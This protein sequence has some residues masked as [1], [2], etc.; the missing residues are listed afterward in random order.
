[1]QKLLHPHVINALFDI[2][3]K[4]KYK[5]ESTDQVSIQE[6][7]VLH[8]HAEGRQ[9]SVMLPVNSR[10]HKGSKYIPYNWQYTT[11][12]TTEVVEICDVNI[13]VACFI[14]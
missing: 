4:K 1:M 10:R 13:S 7:A 3:L 12:K 9:V 14:Q 8:F 2:W 5:Q 6:Q 11:P